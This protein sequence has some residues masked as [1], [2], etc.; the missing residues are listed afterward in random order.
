MNRLFVSVSGGK[1][2]GK[3]AWEIK[4]RYAG[5]YHMIFG[6]ANTGK[7]REETL[8]FVDQMDRE[9]DL[10]IVWVEAVT[11]HGER[12]SS[13]HRVVTFE[14][15][16]RNGEPFESVIQKYGITNK[17]FPHCTRELKRNALNSYL[18]AVGWKMGTYTTVIGIRADEAKRCRTEQFIE[19]PLVHWFPMTKGEVNDWWDEQSFNLRL[20]EHQGNCDCCWKKS[21]NKLVRIAQESPEKFAWWAQMEEQYSMA[22][23]S[24]QPQTF[25]RGHMSAEG[26]LR[27]AEDA[28]LGP[29]PDADED[30]GCSESCEPFGQQ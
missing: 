27:L 6:F 7:E 4:R 14:T 8:E 1:T 19:Y 26:I 10:G 13:S 16:S 22:G 17:P 9:F 12:K 25:F 30:S 20:R 3:M 2:S 24:G 23:P 29:L 21:T 18:R 15:A 5:L 11:N 28:K